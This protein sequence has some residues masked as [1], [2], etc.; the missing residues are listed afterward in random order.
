M[1]INKKLIQTCKEKRFTHNAVWTKQIW[2][3]TSVTCKAVVYTRGSQM[4]A[5]GQ[6]WS[7][8]LSYLDL[9]DPKYLEYSILNWNDVYMTTGLDICL[10][11]FFGP[12][13]NIVIENSWFRDNFK[14]QQSV[15]WLV[16]IVLNNDN[17]PKPGRIAGRPAVGIEVALYRS[18]NFFLKAL[19]MSFVCKVYNRVPPPPMDG[20]IRQNIY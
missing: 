5:Q 2:V 7:T 1:K 14:T 10:W 20:A 4:M 19:K 11:T 9:V 18:C 8:K 12:T 6:I 15:D 17:R 16:S 13:R 3:S